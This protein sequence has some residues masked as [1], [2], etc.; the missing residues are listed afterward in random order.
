MKPYNLK[1]LHYDCYYDFNYNFGNNNNNNNN[2]K[3]KTIFI[4]MYSYRNKTLYI[5]YRN[6]NIVSYR[7]ITFKQ[8]INYYDNI[9]LNCKNNYLLRK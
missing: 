1:K 3:I 2:N 5:N 8:L 9:F 7:N 4:N 6:V